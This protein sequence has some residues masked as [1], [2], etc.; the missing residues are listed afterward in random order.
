MKYFNSVNWITELLSQSQRRS[1]LP[2][3]IYI[4]AVSWHSQGD[5]NGPE[6]QPIWK[7]LKE[8]SNPPVQDIDWVCLTHNIP[9]WNGNLVPE[10]IDRTFLNSSSRM[11]RLNGSPLDLLLLYVPLSWMLWWVKRLTI[12]AMLNPLL[13]SSSANTEWIDMRK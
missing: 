11:A 7:Y 3:V 2:I 8:N 1:V 4:L 9:Q 10:L 12:R 13:S 6:T 5:V